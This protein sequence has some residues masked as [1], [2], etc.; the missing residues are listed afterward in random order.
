MTHRVKVI[1]LTGYPNDYDGEYYGPTI[2]SLVNFTE[3]EEV[4]KEEYAALT[5]WA[6]NYRSYHTSRIMIIEEKKK[7]EI[8]KSI[9]EYLEV[10]K[11]EKKKQEEVNRKYAEAEKKRKE[12]EEKRKL[13]LKSKKEAKEKALFEKLKKQFEP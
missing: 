1:E 12:R 7:E 6:N 5:C 9:S 3:W 11:K 4:T 8:V 10:A 13:T 2:Y